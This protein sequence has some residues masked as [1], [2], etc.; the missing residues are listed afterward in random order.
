MTLLRL[1]YSFLPSSFSSHSSL[2]SF[3]PDYLQFTFIAKH[4]LLT[5]VSGPH[6]SLYCST[7]CI[8]LPSEFATPFYKE[9][10][11]YFTARTLCTGSLLIFIQSDRPVYSLT[12]LAVKFLSTLFQNLWAFFFCKVVLNYS[13]LSQFIYLRWLR[14]ISMQKCTNRKCSALQRHRH[15]TFHSSSYS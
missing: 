3:T 11:A 15:K 7:E 9:P 10:R 1:L 2:L 13:T 4:L 14:K 6:Y 12:T 8:V 5:A